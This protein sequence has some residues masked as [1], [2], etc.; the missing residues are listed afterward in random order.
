[1]AAVRSTLY[2][3]VTIAVWRQGDQWVGLALEFDIASCGPTD[4]EAVEETMDAVLAYLHTQDEL[5]ERELVFRERSIPVYTTPPAAVPLAPVPREVVEKRPA[6]ILRELAVPSPS[7]RS[8]PPPTRSSWRHRS[9]T[10]SSDDVIRALLR[11]GFQPRSGRGPRGSHRV[12]VKPRDPGPGH[13]TVTVP[14][15]KREIP[16]GTLASI[17]RQLGLDR[18][19]FDDWL[20]GK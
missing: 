7:R 13:V 18:Q 12:S 5:G 20:K 16:D 14:L 9:T 15:G 11:H 8:Q 19:T 2:V 10:V 6:I 17:H 4:A 3:P 1:M